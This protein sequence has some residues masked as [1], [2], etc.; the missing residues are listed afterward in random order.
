MKV[1]YLVFLK[2]DGG[3][4]TG[5]VTDG[6]RNMCGSEICVVE[7]IQEEVVYIPDSLMVFQ[8]ALFQDVPCCKFFHLR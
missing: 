6:G 2:L 8:G 4:L 3:N 7:G 1:K 5:V